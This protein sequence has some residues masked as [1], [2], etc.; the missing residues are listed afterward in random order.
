MDSFLNMGGHGG[1]IWP[2]YGFVAAVL[3]GLLITSWRFA[4]LSA[5]KLDSLKLP[6]S[7]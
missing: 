2:A 4:K 6:R 1:F 7:G 5:I 3:L